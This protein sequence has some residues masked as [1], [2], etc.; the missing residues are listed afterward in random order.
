MELRKIAT[1][2]IKFRTETGN[3]KEIEACFDYVLN[4][5]GDEVYKKVYKKDKLAP[6]MLLSN[7]DTLDF[8]VMVVG[9][10]D[11]VPAE[12]EMF[13]PKFEGNILRGRGAL[14]MKSFAAVGM[15]SLEYVIKEKLPLKFGVLLSSD[16]EKG[17]FGLEA[18]LKDY[19]ELKSKIVLDVDVAGDITK[20]IAK[21]KNPAFVKL[22]AHGQEAHGAKPW[23]GIDA[24]EKLLQVWSNIRNK[25]TYF[26]KESPV[27]ENT[28]IN[29]VHMANI[30]GGGA[31]NVVSNYCEAT[32]DFRLT[33][34]SSL[35][36]LKEF[37]DSCLVSGVEYEIMSSSHPV[38]MDEKNPYILQYKKLAEEKLGKKIDFEYIGGAT[39]S[40]EFAQ[41]GSV[42]IMHSG[43]GDG[44]HTAGEYVDWSSVE[45]LLSI[46]KDFLRQLCK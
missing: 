20:I 41:K 22:I 34:N 35:E 45:N 9:H 36:E 6:V 28:W 23:L 3:S 14:D 21:C 12:D 30:N 39:D 26:S 25:Y 8:D 5:F 4:L 32:L 37:L 46:Q 27:P 19:P 11:V 42:V 43:S 31:A 2:L 38:V 13:K 40:R 44:E 10:L 1:D 17:S 7:V 29:T 18:F 24:N 15:K 16:E 33:E